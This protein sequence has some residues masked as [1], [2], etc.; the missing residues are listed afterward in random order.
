MQEKIKNRVE[1]SFDVRGE[2]L[3]A[4]AKDSW[5]VLV[6]DAFGEKEADDGLNGFHGG[7]PEVRVLRQCSPCI[8]T[9]YLKAE[10]FLFELKG[11]FCM[12]CWCV[13]WMVLKEAFGFGN[14]QG[15]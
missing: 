12:G 6:L 11:E 7:C 9:H 4:H 8:N 10:D 5:Q 1:F 2:N 13:K 3:G 15:G 14:Q